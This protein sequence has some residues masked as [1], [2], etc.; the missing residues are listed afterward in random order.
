MT[1]AVA[2]SQK[3]WAADSIMQKDYPMMLN[4][5]IGVRAFISVGPE[6]K[7]HYYTSPMIVI[8]TDRDTICLRAVQ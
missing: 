7:E 4:N 1:V 5:K 3:I 6:D 2:K 8:P